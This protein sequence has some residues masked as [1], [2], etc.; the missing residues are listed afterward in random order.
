MCIRDRGLMEEYEEEEELSDDGNCHGSELPPS[1]E[2]LAVELNTFMHCTHPAASRSFVENREETADTNEEY[3]S[4][5]HSEYSDFEEE[6]PSKSPIAE[7][8]DALLQF[9]TAAVKACELC[10]NE[11]SWCTWR[12]RCRNCRKYLLTCV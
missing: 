3:S 2:K 11:F 8:S 5:C 4:K 10:E 9:E 7:E 12:H 1:L 6:N